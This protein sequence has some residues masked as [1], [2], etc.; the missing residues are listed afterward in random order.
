MSSG[1]EEY[2][3]VDTDLKQITV[4][5]FENTNISQNQTYSTK[6]NVQSFVFNDL[7]LAVQDIFVKS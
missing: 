6:E 4:Y 3:I 2:W 7:T 1:V 5:H